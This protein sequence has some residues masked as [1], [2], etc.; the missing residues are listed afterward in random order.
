MKIIVAGSREYSNK[1]KVFRIL[2]FLYAANPNIEI[3]SGL[4]KGPDS[5]GKEWAE[6]NGVTVHKFP[7]NWNKYGK[8]AGYRRNE[9]MAKFSQILLAFWDGESRGT[10]HMIN[11]AKKHG[12]KVKV[13]INKL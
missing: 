3:V 9:E 13:Y 12:L 7:A 6:K 8:S 10:M 11:L 2:D 1:K 5:Y 4:A